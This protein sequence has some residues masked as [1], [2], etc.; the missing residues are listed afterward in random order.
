M[1]GKSPTPEKEDRF[2]KVLD[3]YGDFLT[4]TIARVC[5]KDLGLIKVMARARK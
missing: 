1:A 4:R 3:Q 2:N 5:P